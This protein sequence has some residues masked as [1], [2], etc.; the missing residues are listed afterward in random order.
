[1][2]DVHCLKLESCAGTTIYP[3]PHFIPAQ[4]AAIPIPLP[5]TKAL[6]HEMIFCFFRTR[7]MFGVRIPEYRYQNP[8][9]S[10]CK[11]RKEI[12]KAKIDRSEFVLFCLA[13]ALAATINARRRS[14]FRFQSTAVYYRGITATFTWDNPRYYR[15]Y[16]GI[17]AAPIA[18][19][20]ST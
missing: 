4:I 5:Y 11:K 2:H 1:M 15:G 3:H 12:R 17:S 10:S 14:N 20:L 16:R 9:I 18:V 13:Y 6:K 8:N 7:L 19:Q